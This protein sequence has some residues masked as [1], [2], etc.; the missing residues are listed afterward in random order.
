VF[1]LF[2]EF[3]PLIK[4]GW[5]GEQ[6]AITAVKLRFGDLRLRQFG[7]HCCLLL[8]PQS[9]DGQ[10]Q[11]RHR[12]QDE[13]QM[14]SFITAHGRIPLSSKGARSPLLRLYVDMEGHKNDS[15]EQRNYL[16]IVSS[17]GSLLKSSPSR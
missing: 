7:D 15:D 8:G 5:I 9:R 12:G 10:D 13:K 1:A 2:P 17:K 4:D 11:A 6:M 3:V 14:D 16:P